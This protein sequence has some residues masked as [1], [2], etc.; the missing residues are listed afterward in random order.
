M[1]SRVLRHP[2]TNQERRL[3]GRRCQF[4][5]IDGFVLNCRAKRNYACLPS[6]W[7]DIMRQDRGDRCWKRHRRTQYRVIQN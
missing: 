7:D 6:A 3:T 5:I 1:K 2:K 4:I